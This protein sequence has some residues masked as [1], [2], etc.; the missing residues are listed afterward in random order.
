MRA[1]LDSDARGAIYSGVVSLADALSGLERAAYS[2]ATVKLYYAGFYFARAALARRGHFVFYVGTYPFKLECCAG[3]SPTNQAGNSHSVSRGLY[4][5]IVSTGAM[6]S[7][8]IGGDHA[9]DWLAQQREQVHYRECRMFD[10]TAPPWFKKVSE[11]GVRK[12]LRAYLSDLQLYAYDP[13][14]AQLALPLAVLVDEQTC[15]LR[16]GGLGLDPDD[17][18]TLKSMIKDKKGPIPL[19]D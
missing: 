16:F 15:Q 14:H 3:A 12:L 18:R 13:D 19:F 17:L 2:W 5:S 4:K 10:P 6:N 7:Q 8:P 1:A 9:F 11:I